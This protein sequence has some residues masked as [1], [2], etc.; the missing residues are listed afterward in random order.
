MDAAWK[1][2]SSSPPVHRDRDT[3]QRD[4]CL[5]SRLI[6]DYKVSALVVWRWRSASTWTVHRESE[7]ERE[8]DL[9]ICCSLLE[10][11]TSSIAAVVELELKVNQAP[12]READS[13]VIVCTR[14]CTCEKV[15][16][17]GQRL[18]CLRRQG[19]WCRGLRCRELTAVID[20]GTRECVCVR[21]DSSCVPGLQGRLMGRKGASR[22]VI[23][24]GTREAEDRTYLHSFV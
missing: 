23:R 16:G 2:E 6:V 14:T 24:R 13:Y 1:A 9:S 4:D 8:R 18:R 3:G 7:S 20:R 10:E 12:R 19:V 22:Q 17:S 5:F 21:Q 15:A 11:M